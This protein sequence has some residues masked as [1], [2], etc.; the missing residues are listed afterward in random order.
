[1]IAS[2]RV[3][4]PRCAASGAES[5]A[6]HRFCAPMVAGLRPRPAALE[7]AGL[8]C[9]VAPPPPQSRPRLDAKVIAGHDASHVERFFV[10]AH[11]PFD[12]QLDQA[13]RVSKVIDEPFK[14]AA[15]TGEH[16]FALTGGIVVTG[17]VAKTT[18]QRTQPR[19]IQFDF[20]D[21]RLPFDLGIAIIPEVA[22][23][24]LFSLDETLVKEFLLDVDHLAPGQQGGDGDVPRSGCVVQALGLGG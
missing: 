14:Q 18:A 1:M 24:F 20:A 19:K 13:H 15:D 22:V 9:P 5:R 10:F 3:V 23:V 11:G 7:S 21:L 16:T 6:G 12:V 2:A 4:K 8:V 17:F